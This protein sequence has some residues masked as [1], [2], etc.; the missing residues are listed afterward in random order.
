[1]VTTGSSTYAQ[2]ADTRPDHIL[3][4]FADLVTVVRNGA[5]G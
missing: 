1:V 4:R 2:L 5:E 3:R